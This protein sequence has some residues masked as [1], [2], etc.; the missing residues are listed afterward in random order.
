MN[1]Q[2]QTLSEPLLAN[3]YEALFR[4]S[5]TLSTYRDPKELFH[6]LASELRSVIQ[7]DFIVVKLSPGP[8]R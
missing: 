6:V 5:Q 7:F 1:T 8:R 2:L 4:V 3:R